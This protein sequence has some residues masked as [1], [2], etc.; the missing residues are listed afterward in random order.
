MCQA[1]IERKGR[2]NNL[3]HRDESGQ[4]EEEEAITQASR[5]IAFYQPGTI[6]RQNRIK[7]HIMS[8]AAFDTDSLYETET[9]SLT[10]NVLHIP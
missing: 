3:K 10:S 4:E 7:N 5:M 1:K 8:T 9:K 6:E 2:L